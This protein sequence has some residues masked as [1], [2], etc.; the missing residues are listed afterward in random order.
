[1]TKQKQKPGIYFGWWIVATAAIGMSTGPGQFAFGA[2]GL[3]MIPLNEE[4]GWSRTEISLVNS[5]AAKY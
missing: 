3:F 2:L 4:F 5:A 1:V